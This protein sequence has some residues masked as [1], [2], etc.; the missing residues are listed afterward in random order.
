MPSDTGKIL[1][2]KFVQVLDTPPPPTHHLV[3]LG[4]QIQLVLTDEQWGQLNQIMQFNISAR[5]EDAKDTLFKK[6]TAGYTKE[7]VL[8]TESLFT[9]IRSL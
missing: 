8:R 1:K 5:Y 9:L 4:K 3:S 6:A 2:A 7:W